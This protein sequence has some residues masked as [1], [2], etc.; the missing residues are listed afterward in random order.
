MS[1]FLNR[2]EKLTRQVVRGDG[3]SVCSPFRG[4]VGRL[5]MIYRS[6]FPLSVR[7][8]KLWLYYQSANQLRVCLFEGDLVRAVRCVDLE[9]LCH[10]GGPECGRVVVVCRVGR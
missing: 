9:F 6:R 10:S 8:D 2:G 5:G 3:I 1:F 7:L 4:P